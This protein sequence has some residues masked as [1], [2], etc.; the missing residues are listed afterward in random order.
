[1]SNELLRVLPSPLT[2]LG[3]EGSLRERSERITTW[4]A[5]RSPRIGREISDVEAN[6]PGVATGSDDR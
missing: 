4:S 1:M 6:F 3:K 5:R 2:L